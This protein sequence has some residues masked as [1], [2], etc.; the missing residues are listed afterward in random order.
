MPKINQRK[1]KFDAILS[2][3]ESYTSNNKISPRKTYDGND[4]VVM[5]NLEQYR[6]TAK[7]SN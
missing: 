1:T 6:L 3:I 4:L 5:R 2:E 7:Y